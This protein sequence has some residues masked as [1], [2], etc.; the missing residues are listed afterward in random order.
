MLIC[1][2]GG[3]VVVVQPGASAIDSTPVLQLVN[4]FNENVTSGGERG[5]VNIIADPAFA[6][7]GHIYLFY[8]AGSPQR[9]R[10]SRFTMT[11][12]TA[13]LASEVVIWQ[14]VS[15][16]NHT[17]HHGG[18]LAFG[19]DGKLY[20]ATGDNGDPPSCQPL[21]SD[22]GKLLRINPDGTV[23]ADNPF[24]DGAG[25]NI[26]AIWARG[27][28]NPFRISLDAPTS[29][30]FIGD[31]GYN[32]TEEINVAARGANFGW[33]LSEGP[34]GDSNLTN[35]VFSYPHSGS[36]S[37]VMGGFVY[38][39]SQFPAAYQGVYF[40]ADFAKNYLRY[41]TLDAMGNVTGSVAFEPANGDLDNPAVGDPVILKPGPDGSLYYLD[42]GLSWS[43]GGVG[44]QHAASVRRIR[45][46]AGNQP[47]IVSVSAIPVSG[48][49]PLNVTFSSSG[50]S[51]PEGL[52]LTYAWTFG[53]G[54]ISSEANPSYTYSQEGVYLARLTV[55]DGVNSTLSDVI[56]ISVGNAPTGVITSPT[57]GLAFRAGD[58]ISFSGTATDLEDGV[59]SADA[60]SWTVRFHHDS[61][62]H[63]VLGPLTGST[64]GSFVVPVSGH[65]FQGNTSYEI[66]L[67]VTD[68]DGLRHDSSVFVFP[69][70]VNLSFSTVPSGL[71]LRIDGI[72]RVTPYV[73]DE[74][75]DFQ[76]SLEALDQSNGAGQYRFLSWSDGGGS[77][78]LHD[79]TGCRTVIYRDFRTF[80]CPD[81]FG[82]WAG[83]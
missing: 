15:D 49:A 8:T 44:G 45:Y 17:D 52:P 51:D 79:C 12:N 7:N 16:S 41:L 70:K 56:V 68:S 38:R 74:V 40:Y 34:S 27:L 83:V 26:D 33:P 57:N 54:G 24:H 36:D 29:R 50:S 55:S 59:L 71:K 25:P 39:G 28:R 3:R 64:S 31:V 69:E 20:I 30:L 58:T 80:A 14:S 1:E 21:T 48:P 22:H 61:H 6:S 18:G 46:S 10:V 65:T 42:L 2:F 63:P 81:G 67:S 62:V 37:G 5:L 9:D 19:L 76:V 82:E 32:T 47:P 60:F 11:G 53:D 66:I 43:G 4:V 35:P 75:V 23:P 78:S 13:S 73:R 77:Q 72:D